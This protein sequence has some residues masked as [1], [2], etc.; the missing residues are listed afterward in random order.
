M[1]WITYQEKELCCSLFC[2]IQCWEVA[3]FPTHLGMEMEWNLEFEIFSIINM[4]CIPGK[5]SSELTSYRT[6]SLLHYCLNSF[7]RYSCSDCCL[8][9]RNMKQFHSTNLSFGQTIEQQNKIYRVAHTIPQSL[10][11]RVLLRRLSWHHTQAFDRVWHKGFLCKLLMCLPHPA[12]M[13]LRSYLA[14]PMFQVRSETAYH[15]FLPET[16]VY[17]STHLK[18]HCY[19]NLPN[20]VT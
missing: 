1:F 5:P 10:E 9:W 2:S 6:A 16:R 17:Y 3:L 18:L 19:C 8:N 13:L 12:F 20:L 14:D 11:K 15:C 7:R 4:I